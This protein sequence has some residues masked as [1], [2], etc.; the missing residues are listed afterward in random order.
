MQPPRFSGIL[1]IDQQEQARFDK[2][3]L[4][5]SSE[6]KDKSSI[7]TAFAAQARNITDVRLMCK[8]VKQIM[9]EADHLIIYSVGKLE[10]YH[11][12]GEHGAGKRISN[13]MKDLNCQNTVLVTARVYGGI[14]LGLKRFVLI[15]KVSNEVLHS[16]QQDTLQ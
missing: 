6:I 5:Q 13:I 10:G 4:L 3:K 14:P 2:I 12:S 8:K 16:L 11:D 9:P 7:F 1:S 15:D